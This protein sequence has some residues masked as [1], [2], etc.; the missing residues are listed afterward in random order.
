MPLPSPDSKKA[1]KFPQGFPFVEN[2][3]HEFP[4]PPLHSRG[5]LIAL[6]L[7]NHRPAMVTRV[8]YAVR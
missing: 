4:P 5:A 8:S 2:G 6:G 7:V 3:E 1:R